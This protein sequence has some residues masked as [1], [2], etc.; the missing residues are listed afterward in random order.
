MRDDARPNARQTDPDPPAAAPAAEPHPLTSALAALQQAS[1]LTR[2]ALNAGLAEDPSADGAA[3]LAAAN[4][5][6]AALLAAEGVSVPPG[7]PL[8]HAAEGVAGTIAGRLKDLADRLLATVPV[9]AGR[10]RGLQSAGHSDPGRPV[11]RRSDFKGRLDW[12]DCRGP[13][14]PVP[15]GLPGNFA[16]GAINALPAG[17]FGRALC[18]EPEW[19]NWPGLG[20]ALV[21]GP[22]TS[23]YSEGEYVRGLTAEWRRQ[24]DHDAA[25][26]EA[27]VREEQAA[28][29]RQ[30]DPMQ[31]IA[32]LE[33]RMRMGR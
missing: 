9:L 20:P 23:A 30:R 11:L 13:D 21:L 28:A 1:D 8:A 7:R 19:V 4:E 17:H 5:A 24:M 14:Y 33:L 31:R 2:R 16:V 15:F 22:G 29:E 3:R 12:A 6:L 26:A 10:V 18:G 27:R 32:D 25:Q